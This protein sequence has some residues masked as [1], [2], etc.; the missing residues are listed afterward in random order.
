MLSAM[1]EKNSSTVKEWGIN[2][3][4]PTT[5]RIPT[6][7]INKDTQNLNRKRNI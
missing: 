6:Q 7:I 3:L 1:K 4:L 5:S 2:T